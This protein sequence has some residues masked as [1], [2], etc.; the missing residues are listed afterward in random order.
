MKFKL[1]M[2]FLIS[3]LVSLTTFAGTLT[4]TFTCQTEMRAGQA[5]NR[6]QINIGEVEVECGYS[7]AD[8][9][10]LRDSREKAVE[11][12]IDRRASRVAEMLADVGPAEAARLAAAVRVTGTEPTM[13]PFIRCTG[14]N[15]QI[16][17]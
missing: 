6:L 1:T 14:S 3:M 9:L 15:P 8:N 16:G 5:D 2:A 10:A 13:P 12:Y 4:Q 11:E 7:C 17:H